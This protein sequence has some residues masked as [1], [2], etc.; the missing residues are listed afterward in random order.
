MQY[1]YFL[2]AALE[3]INDHTFHYNKRSRKPKAGRV[4][5]HRSLFLSH[6]QLVIARLKPALVLRMISCIVPLQAA[7]PS[8]NQDG[9]NQSST[10]TSTTGAHAPISTLEDNLPG[11]DQIA[12]L[13]CDIPVL[14]GNTVG[15]L[16]VCLKADCSPRLCT[17]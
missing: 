1:T 2:V 4:T 15:C 11:T 17:F 13:M 8:S 5:D 14:L 6:T 16:Q 10:G 3:T 9:S 7:K 12:L